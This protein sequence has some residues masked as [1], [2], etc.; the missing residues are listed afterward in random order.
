[1]NAVIARGEVGHEINEFFS[2]FDII[3]SPVFRTTAPVFADYEAFGPPAPALT[4]W[5]NQVGIPAASIYCGLGD[6]G[7]PIGLQ[8]AGKQFSD[9]QVLSVCWIFEEAFGRSP[10]SPMAGLNLK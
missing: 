5:C 3:L 7:L 9:A 2:R 6:L 1:V 8:V 4:N 10:I